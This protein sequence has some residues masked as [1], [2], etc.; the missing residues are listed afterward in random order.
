MPAIVAAVWIRS[1]TEVSPAKDA[2]SKPYTVRK[3]SLANA[4][5]I[6]PAAD[7]DLSGY[8]DF[9]FLDTPSDYNI[10][11]LAG[12]QVFVNRDICGYKMFENLDTRRE[13]LLEIYSELR[14][15]INSLSGDNAEELANACDCLGFDEKQFIFALRVFEELGLVAFAEGRLIV[16]RGAKA[17]LANSVT[18]RK[19]CALQSDE[20]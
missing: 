11:S 14:R 4:L 13:S 1:R 18:Y 3:A 8:R 16:Y 20:A 12:R 7:A 15:S 6:S 5:V 10:S 9:L 2:G 17:E 19:V